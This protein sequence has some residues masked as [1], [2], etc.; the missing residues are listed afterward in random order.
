M[1][2]ARRTAT[3]PSWRR[4][5]WLV[6]LAAGALAAGAAGALLAGGRGDAQAAHWPGANASD[7][8]GPAAASGWG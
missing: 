4:P 6:L 3:A 2:G 7:L 8:G 5:S 1:A